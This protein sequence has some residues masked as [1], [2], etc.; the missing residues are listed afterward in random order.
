V[1][2][3]K[4]DFEYDDRLPGLA[5]EFGIVMAPHLAPG[6]TKEAAMGLAA[7]LAKLAERR[8]RKHEEPREEIRCHSCGS[9]TK[10]DERAR[11]AVCVRCALQGAAPGSGG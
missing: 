4:I 11:V 2:Q 9:P 3:L 6:T 1:D 10:P 7:R 5:L 8:L